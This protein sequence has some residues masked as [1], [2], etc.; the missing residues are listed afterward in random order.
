MVYAVVVVQ[1]HLQGN[2]EWLYVDS[3]SLGSSGRL[4]GTGA[5]QQLKSVLEHHPTVND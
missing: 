3:Q 4:V 2:A 1:A 5:P